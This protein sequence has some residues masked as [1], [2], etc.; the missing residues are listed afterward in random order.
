MKSLYNNFISCHKILHDFHNFHNFHNFHKLNTIF[1]FQIC[2]NIQAI[3]EHLSFSLQFL[4]W[5]IFCVEES[6]CC[7]C[8]VF[9]FCC[10]FHEV[11]WVYMLFAWSFAIFMKICENFAQ[12]L[13]NTKLKISSSEYSGNAE[14]KTKAL[15]FFELQIY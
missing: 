12:N 13:K 15:S 10:I 8:D 2:S 11:Y 7:F 6:I 3:F 9:V 14:T 1:F 5:Q 4:I